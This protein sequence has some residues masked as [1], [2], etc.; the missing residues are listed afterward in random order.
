MKTK[1]GALNLFR[2]L[3]SVPTAPFRETA[4]SRKALEWIKEQ[5]GARAKVKKVRGGYIVSYKGAGKAPALCL[6]AHLDHP[7]FD[8]VTVTAAGA[9]AR[10]RGGLPPHLL[11]GEKVE[12]FPAVP[13]GNVPAA[14]GVL[15]PRPAKDGAPWTIKWTEPP[16][17]A[18][19]FAVLALP[20]CEVKGG[21]LSSRSVDDLLGCAMSLEAMR[22]LIRARAKANLTVLL[23]RAEEVGFVGALDMIR[24]GV[25]SEYD[26]YLS[27]ESSRELPGSR[28]GKGPTIRLGD[29]ATAFDGNATSLLDEAA[30]NLAKRGRKVQRLRLTGGTCEAT[31]YLAFGYEAGGVAVPLVNYHNGWGA[32][33]VAPE[34]VRVSDVEGGTALLFEAARLFNAKIL[35]GALRARLEK[36]HDGEKRSL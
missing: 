8:L 13:E 20:A 15:G 23:N 36:R 2:H 10:L 4:V 30:V 33:A 19:D 28:P 3:T 31:A 21:W 27:I 9:T 26:T 12:A 24:S 17:G 34:R 1:P 14:R 25:L 6:A 5:L 35:R 32:K 18:V 22:R 11:A 29:K 7:A 16:K